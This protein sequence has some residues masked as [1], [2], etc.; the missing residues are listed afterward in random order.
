MT[1]ENESVGV[2]PVLVLVVGHMPLV[3]LFLFEHN[4]GED[5]RAIKPRDTNESEVSANCCHEIV[6]L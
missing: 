6:I 3:A 5:G 4:L 1:G 2:P